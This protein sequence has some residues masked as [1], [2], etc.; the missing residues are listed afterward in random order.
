MSGQVHGHGEFATHQ[1]PT[2]VAIYNA[3]HHGDISKLVNT[4][5]SRL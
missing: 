1:M 3:M 5:W 2:F 4:W